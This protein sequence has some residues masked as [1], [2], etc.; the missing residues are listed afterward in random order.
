MLDPK[1]KEAQLLVPPLLKAESNCSL[2]EADQ[3]F[4]PSLSLHPFDVCEL[5]PNELVFG[6]F[7]VVSSPCNLDK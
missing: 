2:S 5:C 1:L 4:Q 3:S 6:T 7:C